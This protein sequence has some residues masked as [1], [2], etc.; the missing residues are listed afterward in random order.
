MSTNVYV[1]DFA[2]D[3]LFESLNK[4]HFLRFSRKKQ[5]IHGEWPRL[6]RSFEELSQ[7]RLLDEVDVLTFV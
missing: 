2:T 5:T 6:P 3:S 1:S 4:R 7:M